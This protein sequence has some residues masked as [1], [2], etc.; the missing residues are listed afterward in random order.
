MKFNTIKLEEIAVR[1]VIYPGDLGYI[2]Y[3]H[4]A[5]Y[6]KE[7]NHGVSFEV[8]VAKGICEFYQNHDANKDGVWL[9]EHKGKIIGSIFLQHREN[10]TAQLRFFYLESK[11]R[12]LGLGKLLMGLF[13]DFY[14]ECGYT[15]SYL[16]T[17]DELDTAVG[18]YQKHG[19]VLEQEVKTKV[20]GKP[21]I[22][23]KYQL[24]QLLTNN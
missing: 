6:A 22:E 1:T 24:G 23:R 10:R 7:Y 13:M 12:G 2:I 21:L 9:C 4:G 15:S 3:R 8:Y 5:M 16:W 19:Y 17:T 14:R 11:Y 18:L 20:F